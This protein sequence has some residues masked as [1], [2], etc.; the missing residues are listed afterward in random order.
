[1]YPFKLIPRTSYL[2]RVFIFLSINYVSRGNWFLLFNAV[3]LIEVL[4]LKLFT[5]I[6]TMIWKAT[7]SAELPWRANSECGGCEPNIWWPVCD[8]TSALQTIT[9]ECI[10]IHSIQILPISKSYTTEKEN[11]S[12]KAPWFSEVL[13]TLD[14]CRVTLF[15]FTALYAY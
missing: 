13:V 11:A 4:E 7:L 10:K 2:W 6:G 12:V 9:L 1:M 15:I 8:S 3:I 5:Q 14:K